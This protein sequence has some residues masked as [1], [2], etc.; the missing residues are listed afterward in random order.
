MTSMGIDLDRA[1]LEAVLQQINRARSR[2]VADP[3][4]EARLD[5]ALG[6]P[7]HSLVV[8]GTLA[9]GRVNHFHLASLSGEWSEVLIEGELGD[10]AGY[11]MFRHVHGGARIRAWLL[12]SVELPEHYDRLD[13]FETRAY[14]RHLV[15][16][17]TVTGTGVAN[18]YVAARVAGI[19]H[20]Q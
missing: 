1:E 14:D 8:Y 20:G 4:L 5:Q 17:E 7:A 11:P 6:R 3:D 19:G 18:C 9:P 12:R 13:G 10:W 15:P 2:R 16:Y